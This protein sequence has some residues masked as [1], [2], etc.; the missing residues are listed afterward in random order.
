MEE[1]FKRH[2]VEERLSGPENKTRAMGDTAVSDV[3]LLKV[4][5]VQQMS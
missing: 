3:G 1:L 4:R 2:N 5:A